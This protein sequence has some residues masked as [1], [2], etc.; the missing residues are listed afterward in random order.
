[1]FLNYQRTK[2]DRLYIRKNVYTYCKVWNII[3][4]TICLNEIMSLYLVYVYA[5]YSGYLEHRFIEED[6]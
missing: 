2:P 3:L 1:M 5:V 4:K 6:V